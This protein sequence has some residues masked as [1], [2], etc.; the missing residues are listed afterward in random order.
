MRKSGEK[1]GENV[2]KGPKKNRRRIGK[3]LEIWQNVE[4]KWEEPD[5]NL[6]NLQNEKH[7]KSSVRQMVKNAG[8]H[9]TVSIFNRYNSYVTA[10]V[11]NPSNMFY[12]LQE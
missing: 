6:Q 2:G 1:R 10:I 5:E 12:M 9:F 7:E 11:G 8:T 4:P 3:R